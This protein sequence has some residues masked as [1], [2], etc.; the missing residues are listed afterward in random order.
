M[1]GGH[2][3]VVASVHRLQD[4]QRFC[5]AGL[6]DEDPIGPH[7]KAVSEQLANVQLTAALHV[8]R[9]VFEANHVWMLELE[10]G[11]VLD[12]YDAL[13]SRDE[14]TEHVQRGRLA[15]ARP[16]RDQQVRPT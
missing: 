12:C 8:R 3:A 7:A 1:D 15:G 2:A 4:L 11:R 14:R 10:L 13:G 16:A 5:T 9:A 6:S